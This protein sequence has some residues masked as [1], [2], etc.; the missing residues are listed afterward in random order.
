MSTVS[1]PPEPAARVVPDAASLVHLILGSMTTQAVY[2]AAE[3][4]IADVLADGPL[5]PAEIAQK[6][7]A[8][9]EA[10]YRLLRLLAS[11]GVFAFEHG[12]FALTPMADP[13]RSDAPATM[14][15]LARLMG[16][17]I[18]WEDWGH[19]LDSVRTGEP[20]LPKLRGMGAFE[21]LAANPDYGMAFGAGMGNLSDL[22]TTPLAE[23]YDYTQFDTIVDVG[24]G[25]G[26]LLAAILQRAPSARGVLL[27]ERAAELGAPALLE[28][29]G[30]AGRCTV[31]RGSYLGPVPAGGDAYLLKHVVHDW[32]Q[33]QAVQIL[34]N[35]RAAISPTGRLLL[36]E[37]V[38]PDGGMQHISKQV[39]LWL[40]L[41]VGGKERTATQ[42]ADLLATAGFQFNRVVHT[43][44]PISIVE[45]RPI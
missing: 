18:H 5:P 35:V 27:D 38:V 33:A 16:H 13:L 19:L 11:H 39:D 40:M 6:V 29:T 43:A 2:V 15:S 4:G 21:Y 28:Q 44:A 45:A 42:Y 25:R 24:G 9:P 34:Q 14:R 31:E 22:E 12:R 36:M 30:V 1:A 17:P 37:F 26:S 20:S 7:D 3:L 8:D 10:V 23:A 32:P 41:L